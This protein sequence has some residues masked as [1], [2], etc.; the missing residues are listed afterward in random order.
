MSDEERTTVSF[1]L[2]F[3][4][5]AERR[6]SG[7]LQEVEQGGVHAFVCLESFVEALALHDVRLLHRKP[8]GQICA[9]CVRAGF[10]PKEGA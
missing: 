10:K 6:W 3:S 4:R 5:S 2:K 9:T 8:A 1:V 7:R